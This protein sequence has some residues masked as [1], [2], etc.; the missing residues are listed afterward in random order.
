MGTVLIDELIAK[1]EAAIVHH[2]M[3]ARGNGGVSG[4]IHRTL[5][6][7]YKAPVLDDLRAIKRELER[8]LR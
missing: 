5:A 1:Y 4:A 2:N 8:S 7:A 3:K 6:D